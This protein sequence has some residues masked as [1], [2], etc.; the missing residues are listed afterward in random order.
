VR[1]Y[2]PEVRAKTLAAIR[3]IARGEAIAAGAPREPQVDVPAT[4]NH[5]VY[6]DPALIARLAAALTRGLG[7]DRAVEMPPKMTSEDFA[8]YGRAGIPAALLHIGAV[9][10]AK[11]AE[12]KKTGVPVPPPHSPEWAPDLEPTLKGAIRAETTALLE[13]FG[14][15]K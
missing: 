10:A 6:N 4:G 12:A 1:T 15:V 2:T 9:N 11:F 14:G 13:L 8:E 5:P 7:G 3:R